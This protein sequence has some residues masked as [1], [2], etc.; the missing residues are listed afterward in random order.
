MSHVLRIRSTGSCWLALAF[1]AATAHAG[2]KEASSDHFVIYSEQDRDVVKHLA[3]RLERLHA[4]MAH[5]Y[6]KQQV[7]P[8]PSNRITIFVLADIAEVRA[9]S[10]TS[11]SS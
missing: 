1:V 11:K 2:W 4:A 6:P 8:S 7:K 10:R 3:G 9:I 5:L